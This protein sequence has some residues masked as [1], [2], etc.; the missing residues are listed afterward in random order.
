MSSCWQVLTSMAVGSVLLVSGCERS[1]S[2]GATGAATTGTSTTGGDGAGQ[3]PLGTYPP[4]IVEEIAGLISNARAGGHDD[5]EFEW[6]FKADGTFSIS[7]SKIPASL[8]TAFGGADA[9]AMTIEGRWS[10]AA[11]SLTYTEIALDGKPSPITTATTG[12]YKS[13]P[14]IWRMDIEPDQFVF[15]R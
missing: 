10:F 1:Q 12:I 15:A 9:A 7:G 2:S 3:M 5:D 11:R 4:V 14:T 6:V 13:A 8:L